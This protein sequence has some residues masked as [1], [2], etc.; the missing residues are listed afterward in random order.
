MVRHWQ[1]ESQ[2]LPESQRASYM[3]E[4]I[5]TLLPNK[6]LDTCPLPKR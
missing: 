2:Q 1:A 6:R 4:R 5:S 3:A